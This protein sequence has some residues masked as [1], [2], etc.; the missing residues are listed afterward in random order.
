MAVGKGSILRASNAS[1]KTTEEKK[2]QI[3]QTEEKETPVSQITK[4]IRESVLV[5][6]LS[7]LDAE[8][9][10]DDEYLWRVED[11]IKK[12][13]ILEPLI[14]WEDSDHKLMVLDGAARLNAAKRLKIKEVPVFVADAKDEKQAQQIRSELQEFKQFYCEN[15]RYKIISAIRSDMPVHLL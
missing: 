8:S 10:H 6:Q 7:V 14:V 3:S 13:G 4:T 12:Y 5:D 1:A 9:E 15:H 2:S 11:S